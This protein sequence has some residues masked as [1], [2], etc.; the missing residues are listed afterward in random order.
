MPIISPE[1]I[2]YVPYILEGAL[3]TFSLTFGGL[4]LGFLI[5]VP[6]AIGQVYGGRIIKTLLDIYVWFFRGVPLIVQ[7]FLFYW[8]VFPLVFGVKL[9]ALLT[10]IIVLGLR[11]GAYQSQIFRGAIESIEEGQMLAARAIGMTK[12]QAIIHII[13]PQALRIAIPGWT[14]EYAILLKDSAIC[15]ILGVL[16]TLNRT[17]YVVIATGE[18]LIPYIFAGIMFI[19]YTY[20][21][22][23]LF[24][25]IYEKVQIP[26]LIKSGGM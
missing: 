10:S 7:L 3:W 1:F 14:N 2:N 23:K 12:A 11:S 25:M 17:R 22:T 24:N 16:E 20:G 9:S 4:G 21:G 13:L 26:G 15:F 19:I 8:G 18:A 6:I 5:G